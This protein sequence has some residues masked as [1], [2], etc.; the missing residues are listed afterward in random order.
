MK[1][2]YIKML[3]DK[4]MEGGT[5][6]AEEQQLCN[7]FTTNADNLPAEWHVYRAMFG[8]V[9][10]HKQTAAN[11]KHILNGTRKS[12]SILNFRRFV[13]IAACIAVII[14][15]GISLPN[16]NKAYMVADGVKTTD[17][18]KIENEI[19]NV[20]SL[21]TADNDKAFSAFDIL[22]QE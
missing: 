3:I 4:Y 6:V 10:Q 22:N 2:E 18:T 13:E 1:Q 15:L 11:E 16:K 9:S 8:Y 17:Y 5:T 12:A 20:L 14:V 19:D 7:Y 21:V